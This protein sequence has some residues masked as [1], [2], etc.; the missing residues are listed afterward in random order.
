MISS[1][2]K[3]CG[4]TEPHMFHSHEITVKTVCDGVTECEAYLH[5]RH[6]YDTTSSVWCNGVCDCGRTDP[7]GPGAHK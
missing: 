6:D 7:H 1:N 3:P 4:N 2:P 5:P